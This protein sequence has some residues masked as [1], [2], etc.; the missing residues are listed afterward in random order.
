MTATGLGVRPQVAAVLVSVRSL[1]IAAVAVEGLRAQCQRLGVELVVA[2]GGGP[3]G[4]E[5]ARVFVG[6][7]LVRCQPG[8]SVPAIRG[9]G[10]AAVEAEWVALTEDNCVADPD[11]LATLMAGTHPGVDV[12]GGRMDNARTARALDWGAFFAE[13]GFFGRRR[14]R[15]RPGQPPLVTGANVAYRRAVVPDVAAWAQ[16]G[17]WEDVIHDHLAACGA[18]FGIVPEACVRQNLTY[19]LRPFCRDRYL[20][21][22]DYAV[23]RAGSAPLGRRV[24][25]AL[26]TPLLPPL[27]AWRVWRSAGRDAPLP[28]ARALPATLAFFTAWALGE[29]VGYLRGRGVR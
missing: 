4:S 18:R 5:Q 22:H 15:A 24:L 11:W 12:L 20:H 16:E 19:A 6:C 28:F 10:L 29:A 26:A 13:Y 3:D 8:A 27:L 25:L 17:A 14:P 7:R 2:R 21:G 23:A 9:V 1:E